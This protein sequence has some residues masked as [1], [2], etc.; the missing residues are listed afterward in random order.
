MRFLADEHVPPAFARG[1]H[2]ALPEV[3]VLEL[4]QTEL[5]GASDPEVLAWAALEGR[6]LITRDVSTVPG[7]AFKRI[8]A[9]EPMPG[10]FIW[11]RRASLGE[12]LSDLMLVVQMSRIE[13]WADSVVY[14][15]LT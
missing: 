11:R 13:E 9:G 2:R 3:D 1:L 4:R 8:Q 5:L 12:V 6:I 10:V 15:P 14:L 7:Y